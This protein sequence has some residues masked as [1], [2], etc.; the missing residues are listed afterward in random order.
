MID[1]FKFFP[2]SHKETQSGNNV[3]KNLQ[4][5]T[6]MISQEVFQLLET[7]ENGLLGSEARERLKEYGLNEISMEKPPT[8]YQLL[9]ISYLNPFNILLTALILI[10]YFLGDMDGTIII[11]SM[12]ALS[13]GIR[14]IQEFR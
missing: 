6:Q 8:W 2:F 4:K 10:T 12:V 5:Y 3:T 14:F 11:A 13:I 9:L 7:D 1:M